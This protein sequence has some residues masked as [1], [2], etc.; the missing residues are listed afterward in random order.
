MKE[1]PATNAYAGAKSASQHFLRSPFISERFQ[2]AIT[3]DEFDSLKAARSFLSEYMRF[4]ESV[5]QVLY[6]CEEFEAFLLNTSLNHY[7]FPSHEHDFMQDTRLR[8]NLKVL[9]FLNSVTSLRDQF[10]KFKGL[11]PALDIHRRFKNLWNDQKKAST[12]FSFCERLRN[13]AQHQTQPVSS[14]TTGGGWDKDRVLLESHVSIF[15]AVDAVCANRCIKDGERRQYQ[16]EF[17][18]QCDVSLVFRET[19]ACIGKIVQE[20]R[21]A[22]DKHFVSQM[23]TY[24]ANLAIA[25]SYK[26]NFVVAEA[27][28]TL[29]D[30]EVE[31]FSIF[32]DF[33]ERAKRLRRTFVMTN[34]HSHFISNRARGHNTKR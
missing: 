22:L 21:A 12:A 8:S 32:Q 19:T 3:T 18:T 14:V 17:G 33:S 5:L 31:R 26:E 27:V 4:E 20:T 9:G 11:L 28:S 1:L 15:V 23:A 10:P 2:H 13:Y 25:K 30:A 16:A 29:N 24:E 7:L 34:N 6:S